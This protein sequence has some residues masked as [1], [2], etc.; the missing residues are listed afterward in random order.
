[1]TSWSERR[2]TMVVSAAAVAY[3]IM[4]IVVGIIL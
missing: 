3:L 1:M 4:A 2:R